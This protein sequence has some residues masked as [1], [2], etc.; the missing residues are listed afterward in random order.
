MFQKSNVLIKI[1]IILAG[2]IVS[3]INAVAACTFWLLINTGVALD[4]DKSADIFFLMTL[5]VFLVVF[6]LLMWLWLRVF[7]IF[8]QKEG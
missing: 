2:V 4:D 6:T 1:V 7:E 3:F 5:L 8:P